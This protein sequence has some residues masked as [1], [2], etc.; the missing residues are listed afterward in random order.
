MAKL[1]ALTSCWRNEGWGNLSPRPHYPS[2][3]KYPKG[4]PAATVD[5]LSEAT[6]RLSVVGMSCAA[7]AGSVEKAVKRLP[8]IREA[9]VDLLNNRA[10][11]IFYPS[12]VNEETI[13]EAIEDAGFEA[14][15]LS[16]AM[17]EKS[18]QVCRVRIKGMTCTSCS[19]TLESVLQAIHGVVEAR[20]GLATEEAQVH[21]NPNL[22]THN[23]ILQAIQDSGF[24]PALIS[25]SQELSKID[26]HVEGAV[27]EHSIKLIQDSLLTL[28]GVLAVDIT[29]EFNKVS[30]SYKP[31]MTGPRNFINVIDETGSGNFKAKIY[32]TEQGHIDSHRREETRQYYRSF[33]WSLVFTVPVFLTS[34]VL[35]Y[36]PVIKDAL[37]A[38]L[39]NML[40]VGEVARW[41]LATP[42]QFVLGWRFYYGSYKSLCRGSANMDV[43]I[44]LG[45]N[46]A[47]F[48]SVYSVLRATTSRHFEGNDFFETS[49]M[50]ISFILLGKYLEILAKGKTSD[51]IAKLMNLTPDS[52][53][54]LSVDG[55]GNVV[56][57]EEIDSRLV[58]KND[59]IKVVPGAKVASDG[60]VVWGQSHVNESMITG[61][62]RP[63]AKR[64]GD[65]VIGGTVNENGVL[66]VKATKVGSESAL[67]QI[68]GLVES[69]QMAKAPVQKFADR[70]SKFF[71]PLVIVISFTTW[72]AWFLAGRFHAYPKSWI[73]SS[74][75]SFELALQF[76]I[77][78]MVIACPCAL[79]LATPTAVMV[80]T[81]VGASQGVLIK[82]GQALESAHKVNCIVFDKT[83]TLTVGKP[84]I[85]KTELLTKMVPWEFYEL[86]AAAEANSKHPLAKAIVEYAK[87]FRDEENPSWPEARDFVSITGHGVKATVHNKEIIVGNKSLL[88]DH[89]I[90]IPVVAEDM[91]N[92]A[93]KMA[94]T[95]ILVSI[96]GKVAGVLAVSDPLK[97]GAQEVISILKSMK[98]RS[99][100]VTGDNYGTAS[101]VAREVGIENVIAEAKPDQKAE[102]V[103]ELQASGCTVAMVGDGINDSPAL[104][105]ADVGMAIG[106]GTDIAIEAADIV[107]MK[108]NLEDVITAIDLSRKT[109]SRIRL[110][111]F[112]ALG[113]N[114]LGIPIA[115]G[116]LFPSTRFR[117]PPWIAGAAMAASS[118]SVVCCSLLLKYYRRPTKLNNLQIRGI[119]IEV[120]EMGSWECMSRLQCC[121]NLSPQAHYPSSME[122]EK[123]AQGSEAKVV[124]SVLGM[125]C[126]ACAGSVEKAIK[127]LPGIRQALVD[128]LNDK[129]QV[130]YYP[131]MVKEERIREAIEDAGFEAKAM[132]EESNDRSIEICRIHVG[133]MT[134]TSCSSTIESAL[135][136]LHGVH[137]AR[138]ALATEEAEV[139]YDPNILTHNHL[140]EAIRDTGFEAILISTGEHIS[141][142]ELKIDGIKNDQ[143][144]NAIE[145]SLHALP[146]VESIDIYPDTNKV[147]ITY[148]PY[149]TGPRTFLEVIESTGS[150][151]FKAVIFPNDGGREAQRQEEINRYFKLFIWSLTFTIPVF[152]TSMVLMYIPGVKR[153]LDIKIVNMLSI[154]LL[155][156]CEFATPVQFIIGRRFY[157]GAY[158]ALRKGSANMDVLIALGT[159]AAYFYS[160]YV[161]ERAAFSRHFKGSDFFETSSMLI[162]FILLG[163]YLEV[164]AKGK[165][166]QAIAK[167]MDLTPETATLLTHDDEGN[168]VGER[169]I[170]SRLIQKDDVIKVVPGSKVASDG[171]VIWG[172]SHVNESMITGEARPVAKRK[173]D[174][175][176]G[177][178]VNENG[179]LH[180]KV[181]RVG[182]ES[183][184]SQIVRLVESAQMAKAPVQKLAD[185]ISKYF[186]PMVIVLSLSTW[187]SWF[188]A[189]KLHA[190]PKSWIPSSMNSFELA[191]QFGI[192]VMVIACPCALGLATPTAVMVG[193]G[194]GATQGVLIKGGQALEKAHKVNCIVFDKTGT[195]TVG[196]P[197]VVTTKLFK[198]LSL[199]DFYEFSAA[200][201]ASLLPFTVN[202]EHPIAKAIVEHAKKII[203]E[204]Q[205]HPWA[206]ARDFV[207][208]P[209]HGVK[210]NVRNKEIMVGNKKMMLDNNIA[211]SANAEETLAE[212]ESLAQTGIIVSLDGEVAGILAVSDPLKP[213][214]KEVISILNSMKIKS[215]MVTGD[216]WGTANSIASQAG[217]ET[218]MAEAQP[219][220]KATQIKEL[221]SSG[222]TV[223]MVGDGI[224][225]SPALVA[226]DVGMAIGAG[227]DIAIEAAD[228]VL[229][230]SNL[231]DIITAI[232]LA[233]KTFSRIR[234][235]Y[236]WAL[237]YN[238][239]A[240]PIA[241]G[242]LYSST[243]FR[244][245]PWIAGAA[246]AASSLSVVC[247]SLLLKNYKRPRKLNNLEINGIRIE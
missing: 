30:V 192:S 77:S 57:E 91:L 139:R 68:V 26:L 247:S 10:H 194:V 227:T 213:G 152:L 76:G 173:G 125:T 208:V 191:L 133:G 226:A 22:V 59:V 21:Y 228:I 183:A 105:A 16:D 88:A 199:K 99:I 158:K 243:R 149:M 219:E 177:G 50:L 148:K 160:V 41:V 186:V 60:F 224:N 146:G 43:L 103:K 116:A 48:Y 165:T 67:S 156:R 5:H 63:V 145:H 181:T 108:S 54:L 25:S 150:G 29:A 79:G 90:A 65:A 206:E 110:N 189:G 204:E 69:A 155:L 89:N 37:D 36:V 162:S 20:V 2:M 85:V 202:S 205:N 86:V 81:G 242:I 180:V 49:A 75:D 130:L 13:R 34:M 144:L 131:H 129:A 104:V 15:L 175:V 137:K 42:V 78:V 207:S 246:M 23:H 237:G 39:V 52:A 230:K 170:D 33:L 168:V 117:L 197:V 19:S 231:E 55:D 27:T 58:Q 182:S 203:E 135:Q 1:L 147:V 80:G 218:V 32:P 61:E 107:L 12:F 132:Q 233:N 201:E 190:Y 120:S 244:L 95:G 73:P 87:K 98:I 217:I 101:S 223:A 153:V 239:L 111:Y 222:Y 100:M 179:V 53:V 245:P 31:D 46:T 236:I 143:S 114:L 212:A 94:Q 51:A 174:M 47:Y 96:N 35:M 234:L 70:I 66:H 3:P 195:L 127:R 215:I 93:E 121:G 151:C 225:D 24:E 38:K 238:L 56:G 71:V 124:F 115:A 14:V 109:F 126:A 113:Y 198:K 40:T 82:G 7:C 232:D 157:V 164:L 166:S 118:V 178:T 84:V 64:K 167:L 6:A 83:G 240:I 172:Q 200:A 18:V 123:V 171:F 17:Q 44:A 136:S 28:P 9:V 229:M 169:Q 97:P 122:T 184:L 92:E 8:G 241:A 216:N 138:V 187:L 142:I 154:G 209:G 214:A 193:T 128:V 112:W 185:H 196:K 74:M 176:I 163:K 235:N 140:M 211:I 4:Q 134:C 188:L 102:K 220:T 119:T 11:V 45:T 141:K 106:A 161:V 159:N 62:A 221:Q 72:L 210:A